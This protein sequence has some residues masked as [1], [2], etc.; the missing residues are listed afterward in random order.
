M[1]RDTPFITV[2]SVIKQKIIQGSSWITL[3]ES[4][5]IYWQD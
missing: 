1:V 5:I 3:S 2:E 4:L